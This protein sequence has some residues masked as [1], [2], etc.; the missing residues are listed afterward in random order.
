M[1]YLWFRSGPDGRP[2][3]AL[4]LFDSA[5]SSSF[6]DEQLARRLGLEFTTQKVLLSGVHGPQEE[7]MAPVA[8]QVSGTKGSYHPV[9][10]ALTRPQIC[11]LY[12]SDAA[13]E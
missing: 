1:K 13:D 12:T 7:M 10:R 3:R 4:A 11:L 2:V 8:F 6:I 9:S 5:C